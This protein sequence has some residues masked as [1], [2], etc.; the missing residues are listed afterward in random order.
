V[1]T[2]GK[3]QRGEQARVNMTLDATHATAKFDGAAQQRPV[4]GLD[5]AFDLAIP[6]VGKLAAWLKAPLD[7]AQP[8]PGRL[9]GHAVFAAAGRGPGREARGSGGLEASADG[10][11]LAAVVETGVLDIDRYLPPP[12]HDKAAASPPK[13]SPKGQAAAASPLAALSDRPFDLAALRRID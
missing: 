13:A 1:D 6:S 4:P 3:L 8:D 2:I 10:R 5:G 11:R 7:T 12:A 9:R